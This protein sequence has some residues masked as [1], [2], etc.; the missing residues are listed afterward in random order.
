MEL[1]TLL[2]YFCMRRTAIITHPD[3]ELHDTGPYHPESP[4]RLHAIIEYLQGSTLGSQVTWLTPGP[5]AGKWIDR[6]HDTSYRKYVEEVCLTGRTLLDGGDTH[7][8]A[9]SYHA[10]MLSAGGALMA[11]DAVLRDGF[12]RV[13]VATRPPG[14]HAKRAEAMGFCLFNN[15]AI[16]ARYAQETYGL[17][18]VVIVDWDVHHGNGTQEAFYDDPSVL[19]VSLHQSPLYPDSGYLHEL[20]EGDGHGHT[21]NIPLPPG[22]DITTYRAA[23]HDRIIPAVNDF[24]PDLILISAGFDAHE[25]DPLAGMK[26]RTQDFAEMT[27]LI[28]QLTEIHC[29]GRLISLLEGGYNIEALARSVHAHVETL[30][31]VGVV[32][33]R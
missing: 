8:C 14:H 26:L 6:I 22:S 19:F 28:S 31:E 5:A 20:G 27:R 15:V 4:R 18:R 2:L 32:G 30:A 21:V 10:A 24:A 23:F 17:K 9:D 12:E 7:V 33:V 1:F 29:G 16:A 13:F 3:C 11:I 25:S